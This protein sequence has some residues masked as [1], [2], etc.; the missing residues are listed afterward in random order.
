MQSVP[1]P[2]PLE[3]GIPDKQQGDPHVPDGRQQDIDRVPRGKQR[4]RT[5]MSS[6][7]IHL[8]AS[9][10]IYN[11]CGRRSMALLPSGSSPSP[12]LTLSSCSSSLASSPASAAGS[13]GRVAAPPANRRTM[14]RPAKRPMQRRRPAFHGAQ[15][16][17]RDI[18]LLFEKHAYFGPQRLFPAAPPE[19]TDKPG[20]IP[21]AD[22]HRCRRDKA[23]AD[24]QPGRQQPRQRA[25]EESGQHAGPR[26][27]EGQHLARTVPNLKFHA[28][29]PIPILA[30]SLVY[31]KFRQIC[32]T[33]PVAYAAL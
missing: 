30:Y 9:Y 17:Q 15:G 22:S 33:C 19:R 29:S 3:G 13:N 12:Q 23:A 20:G 5:G 11:G 16:G 7:H 28:D 26:Y 18:Q 31:A 6:S 25:D 32:T 24:K 2:S 27:P 1:S 14:V 8:R 10:Q 4:P 21:E